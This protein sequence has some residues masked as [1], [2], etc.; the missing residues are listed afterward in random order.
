MKDLFLCFLFADWYRGYL[1]KHKML[2][3]RTILFLFGAILGVYAWPCQSPGRLLPAVAPLQTDFTPLSLGPVFSLLYLDPFPLHSFKASFQSSLLPENFPNM[4]AIYDVSSP[5]ESCVSYL[6]FIF[7]CLSLAGLGHSSFPHLCFQC[8][9]GGTGPVSALREFLCPS[10]TPHHHLRGRCTC[11]AHFLTSHG[12]QYS[13]LVSPV[14]TLAK[15]MKECPSNCSTSLVNWAK[16]MEKGNNRCSFLPPWHTVLEG[17]IPVCSLEN[18][19]IN[20]ERKRSQIKAAHPFSDSTGWLLS[21]N[22]A[23]EG[24][25]REPFSLRV[26]ISSAPALP[27]W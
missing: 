13:Y 23:G 25:G 22:W 11:F 14:Y 7:Y 20:P 8:D 21:Q 17:M 3:V 10:P 26:N 18:N 16:L 19:Q 24:K 1:V 5:T 27:I 2:Q 12:T 6:K 4:P 9:S 15:L